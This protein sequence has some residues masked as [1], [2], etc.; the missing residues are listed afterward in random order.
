MREG[1]VAQAQ[2]DDRRYSDHEAGGN[3]N[4]RSNGEWDRDR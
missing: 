2:K 1:A 3:A 4:D